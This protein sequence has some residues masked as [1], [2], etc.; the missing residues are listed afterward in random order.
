M[1]K[2]YMGGLRE[3]VFRN[4]ANV[5][6]YTNS[7]KIDVLDND[8]VPWLYEKAF[9]FVQDLEVQE[10]LATILAKDH[11]IDQQKIHKQCVAEEESRKKQVKEAEAEAMAQKLKEK[12]ERK[13]R[14]DAKRRKEQ[15]AALRAE[16]LE[17]FIKKGSAATP[18]VE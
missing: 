15:E 16:I 12:A 17:K 18:I 11:L 8:V 10:S 14:K 2:S 7:F 4:L 5:G 3:N 9:E 13:A 1:A 6:F